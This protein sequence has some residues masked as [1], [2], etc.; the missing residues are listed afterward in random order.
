V[1]GKFSFSPLRLLRGLLKI[2]VSHFVLGTCLLA[3]LVTI[4]LT[5]PPFVEQ[6]RNRTFDSYQRLQPRESKPE[7]MPV[8]VAIIDIDDESLETFG[9]WPWPRN[10]LANLVQNLQ[11]YGVLVAG[12]DM[13]FAEADRMSP[14]LYA[15]SHENLPPEVSEKLSQL[16]SNEAVFAEQIG[17][18]RVVL[19]KAG[20]H[21]TTRLDDLVSKVGY[22]A[23]GGDPAPYLNQY[24]GVINNLPELE[25]AAA[26]LGLFS[27]QPERDGIYRRVALMERIG[28]TLYPSLSLEILRVALGGEDDYLLRMR[29]DGTGVE[30]IIVKTADRKNPY[31]IPTDPNSKVWVYFSRYSTDDPIYVSAKDVLMGTVKH[32]ELRLQNSM[33][34]IGTSAVG[35]KDIRATPINSALPGVEVHAQVLETILSGTHLTRPDI[36]ILL[37]LGCIILGGLLMI[38]MVPRLNAIYTFLLAVIQISSLLLIARHYYIEDRILVDASYPAIAVFSMFLILSYLNYIREERERAQVRDAFG[39]YV[40]PALLEQLASNPDKLKLGGEIRTISILFSDIRGFTTISEQFNAQELTNFINSFL[41]PMTNVIMNHEGTIDKY[42]GDAI[43]AFWNAPLDVENH[44]EKACTAA[45]KM[46]EAVKELNT[47][48]EA[49]AAQEGRKHIPINI[50]VGINTG[51]CCVGNMGSDQRFD[52]S[53]LGDDVNLASRL[54]GQSKPYGV[55]IVLG[56]NTYR[57][58]AHQFACIELDWLQ[59]KGK[60]EPVTIYALLGDHTFRKSESFRQL[61]E[62]NQQLLSK[63][64]AKEWEKAID[65]SKDLKEKFPQLAY[66]FKLHIS[67]CEEFIHNPPPADWNGVFIATSK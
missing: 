23:I 26:G 45:L 48:Y 9:Q 55:D 19:G 21:R 16:P 31:I 38:L 62:M 4:Y 13:V 40:S 34:I 29:K 20:T 15:K 6:L 2:L 1:K 65:I 33:A 44:A 50:G 10:L 61:Q 47:V 43:M 17:K 27:T 7:D 53:A 30:S 3:G 36:S 59:V 14:P 28:N 60:T 52:Y 57:L 35:L 58:I 12:F 32:P 64:R 54:E 63:Y 49:K 56:E 51:P 41:T 39:H 37:E 66:L 18:S 22:G 67:R 42:M 46:Q 11:A 25:K 8:R 5:N 24:P